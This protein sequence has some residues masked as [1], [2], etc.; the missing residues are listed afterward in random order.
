MALGSSPGAIVGIVLR[1]SVVLAAAGIALGSVGTAAA[2]LA[3]GDLLYGV[4]PFDGATLLGVAGL[5][6]IVSLGAAG[7]PAWRAA[8][9]DPQASL[10]SE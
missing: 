1:E 5:V 8:T 10:R 4:Q 3:I 2:T 6:G 9:V 7:L